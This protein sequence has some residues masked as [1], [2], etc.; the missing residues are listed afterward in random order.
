MT[1][2][3]FLQAGMVGA[4]AAMPIAPQIVSK[5]TRGIEDDLNALHAQKK[6]R[7]IAI[8]DCNLHSSRYFPLRDKSQPDGKTQIISVGSRVYICLNAEPRGYKLSH[9]EYD[10]A[11]NP[12]EL[13]PYRISHAVP[14]DA[15]VIWQQRSAKI[16]VY[17]TTALMKKRAAWWE[18]QGNHAAAQ[19]DRNFARLIERS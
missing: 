5:L 6:P 18:N 17:T 13:W 7:L 19:A 12:D 4:I 16:F 15:H 10:A 9:D 14:E 8:A 11:E 3:E 2:K 1:R